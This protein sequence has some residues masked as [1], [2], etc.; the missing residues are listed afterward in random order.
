MK[1]KKIVKTRSKAL[2]GFEKELSK[3]YKKTKPIT[4]KSKL[5]TTKP[6]KS[7]TARKVNKWG[8]T[9]TLS[10]DY[11]VYPVYPWPKES[12]WKRLIDKI[13]GWMR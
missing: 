11:P 12:W 8:S 1:K 3:I 7:T 2:K 4:T 5:G 6:V 10:Y 9:T 13:W